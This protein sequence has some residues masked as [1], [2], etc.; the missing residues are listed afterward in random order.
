MIYI[1]ERRRGTEL[2]IFGLLR[3]EDLPDPAVDVGGVPLGP[4]PE[5][6]E[7]PVGAVPVQ[8][9]FLPRHGCKG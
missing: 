4:Q 8:A 2:G 1:L 5:V 7:D 6:G 9:A 3:P